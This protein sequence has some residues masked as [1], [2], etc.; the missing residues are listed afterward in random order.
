MTNVATSTQLATQHQP[1]SGPKSQE[2]ALN[3]ESP[4]ERDLMLVQQEFA[5]QQRQALALSESSIIP[6]QFQK[7]MPNCMIA[8]EMA[9]RLNTGALEIMQNLYVVHGRPSFSSSYLIAKIN[10]SKILKGRLRFEFVGEP[11]TDG[12]GCYA[13]GT[14]RETGEDLKGTLITMKMAKDEGWSTKNGSKWKT[15]PDQMLQYRAAAFWSRVNA[16]DATLGMHTTDEVEDMKEINPSPQAENISSLSDAIKDKM[17]NKS[18]VTVDAE[19][20]SEEAEH[21]DSDSFN[22]LIK[23]LGM[24]ETTEQIDAVVNMPDWSDLADG[25]AAKLQAAVEEKRQSIK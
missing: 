24:A 6:Q 4:R 18:P 3:P 15:M 23:G 10:T 20:D 7:N 16:P 17:L 12:Y 8:L 5:L 22:L 11:G 19:E 21:S 1:Q 13:V 9:S 2:L 14:C 25:E